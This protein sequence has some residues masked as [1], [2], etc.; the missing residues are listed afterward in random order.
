MSLRLPYPRA[1][2]GSDEQHKLNERRRSHRDGSAN[3]SNHSRSP[4]SVAGIRPR[5]RVLLEVP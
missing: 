4:R 2:P 1:R 3:S 5:P